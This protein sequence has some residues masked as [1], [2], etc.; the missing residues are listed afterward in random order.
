MVGAL[1]ERLPAV[2]RPFCLGYAGLIAVFRRLDYTVQTVLLVEWSQI[3]LP[4]RFLGKVLLAFFRFFENFSLLTWSLELCPVYGNGLTPYYMGLITQMV[5]VFLTSALLGTFVERLVSLETS[6]DVAQHRPTSSDVLSPSTS[7]QSSLSSLR[8]RKCAMLRCCECVW[9]PP[10]I[11]IGTHSLALVIYIFIWKDACYKSVLWMCAIDVRYR[12]SRVGVSLLP[13]TGH[14]SRLRATPDIF[15]ENPKNAQYDFDLPEYRTRYLFRPA[16]V[17][18]SKISA[19]MG[20]LDRSDTTASQ[21]TDVKQRLRCVSEVTGDTIA[22]FPSFL[23]T[24]FL[25]NP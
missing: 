13:Y 10:I 12:W 19:R 17:V 4:L 6:G 1:V 25:N 7:V 9:L 21:K 8:K 24:G 15:F 3:L 18:P 2:K 22:L 14:N 11:F 23:N 5:I 20:R 16:V